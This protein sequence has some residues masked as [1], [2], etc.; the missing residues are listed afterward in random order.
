MCYYLFSFSQSPYTLLS[1]FI[2]GRPVNWIQ[3]LWLSFFAVFFLSLSRFHYQ[4]LTNWNNCIQIEKPLLWLRTK[5]SWR[6]CAFCTGVALWIFD[7]H[8]FRFYLYCLFSISYLLSVFHRCSS[9]MISALFANSMVF[10]FF[11]NMSFSLS[12]HRPSPDSI[13]LLA[14]WSSSSSNV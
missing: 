13:N 8:I 7:R 3:L 11:V 1:H 10:I 9:L 14:Y 4:S 2:S 6:C 12:H 5:H